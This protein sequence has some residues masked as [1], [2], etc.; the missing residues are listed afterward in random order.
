MPHYVFYSNAVQDADLDWPDDLENIEYGITTKSPVGSVVGSQIWFIAGRGSP[1]QFR[2]CYTFTADSAAPLPA[3]ERG[4]RVS[5]VVGAPFDPP[6][7][8]NEQSWFPEL[9]RTQ[10]W[11]LGLFEI[12]SPEVEDG[13]IALLES[14]ADD[15]ELP[16]LAEVSEELQADVSASLASPRRERLERLQAAPRIPAQFTVVTTAFA[17]NPDVIAE[18]LLRAN[19]VCDKCHEPAPFSRRTDGSPY[20]EV[21]HWTPLSQGGEDTVENAGALCPNC[22]RQSHFGEVP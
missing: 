1:K 3:G 5:G 7:P 17:R 9:R 18:V 19:G 16:T 8:L 20:L 6:I 11:S 2:L 13:L 21:H 22:H 4:A 15:D 10:F 12:Q 14:I